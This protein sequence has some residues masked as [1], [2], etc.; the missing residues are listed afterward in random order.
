M[1]RGVSKLEAGSCC[2]EG[3]DVR[4]CP[5]PTDKGGHM[6]GS[7]GNVVLSCGGC[8]KR[9]VVGDPHWVGRSG[10]TFFECGCGAQ[11]TLSDQL[12]P[13]EAKKRAEIG[14]AASCR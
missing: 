14:A 1:K 4:T 3:V 6:E 9:T 2:A 5:P 12:D 7:S 13:T 8:G 10:R 11:L